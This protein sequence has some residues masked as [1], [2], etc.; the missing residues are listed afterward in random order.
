[1]KYGLYADDDVPSFEPVPGYK[2]NPYGYRCR[3]FHP[4]PN[5]GKN[6]VV[7]GCSHTFGIG[8]EDGEIWI[9]QVAKSS[10]KLF[11]WWNLARPGGSADQMLRILYGTEKTLFPKIIVACW[12]SISR[13][14]R[15]SEHPQ[16]LTSDNDLLKSEDHYTDTNN[17]LKNVFFLEKFAEKIDAKTFHCFAEEVH[18]LKKDINVLQKYTIKNCWPEWNVL[19]GTE[20]ITHFSLARDGVHYGVEHHTTFAKIFLKQFNARIR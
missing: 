6:I 18:L 17:F 2:T 20:K 13:R 9:N 14:E 11:R 19:E 15:L 10:N 8:L 4:L 12:P 3:E 1:M 7:L 5:G 16:S